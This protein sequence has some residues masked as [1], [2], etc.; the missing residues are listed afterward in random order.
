MDFSKISK[1]FW[2]KNHINMLFLPS[3]S[4]RGLFASLV[5]LRIASFSLGDG[6]EGHFQTIFEPI[7]ES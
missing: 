1:I 7:S 2:A 3:K 6:Q 5:P 4:I